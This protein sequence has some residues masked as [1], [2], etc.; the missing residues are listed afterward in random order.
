LGRRLVLSIVLLLAVAAVVVGFVFAGSAGR[1]AA[2][3][4]IAGVDVGGL[5]AK[6]AT[7]KLESRYAAAAATPGA[8]TAGGKTFH[9]PAKELTVH[10]DFSAAVQS[11]LNEGGGSGVVRGF[12]RL[13]LKF[14]PI[15]VDPQVGS[16]DA[17]VKYDM[18]KIAASVDR[19]ERD[20]ELVRHGLHISVSPGQPGLVLDQAAAGRAVVAALASFAR[21]PVALP[22]HRTAPSL[23]VARL[24][25]AQRLA[26]RIVASPVTLRLGATQWRVP[27]W[28]LATLLQ[29][30][31]QLS[32]AGPAADRYFSQLRKRVNEPAKDATW[33]PVA[34][35]KVRLVAAQPGVAL[36]IERS[37]ELLLAAAERT[38]NRLATL[39]T[40]ASTPHR[41]TAQAKAMNIT[42][43]VG[44][45][46]TLYSGVP[47]RLHNVQLVAQ[48][49]DGKLIAPNETFS[50]N[51]ATGERT[52]AKGF[53]V[54]PVIINGEVTTGLGGGVCQVS[55][56]VFNAAFEAGLPIT[57][58]TNHA[59]YISH[60]PLGRDAT[61]DYPDVDLKFVN[62]TGHW[63][64]LRTFV[65][66]DSLSVVLYG[67]PQ[68]RR[69]EATAAPLVV[70]GKLPVKKT[71]DATLKPGEIVVDD[72]G[73]PPQ[74]TSVERKVYAENGTLLSDQTW[75]STYRAE[76]K[77]ERVGRPKKKLP[78]ARP[79]AK[80][81]PASA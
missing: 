67:T 34:G 48:L 71:V 29:L 45:Y 78:K 39:A 54:A 50:F 7:E 40:Q 28:R 43:T 22:V 36:D 20:A 16:Y 62:D 57:S 59:L 80:Q 47:N 33:Q 60:Y 52:A 55:T 4:Q 3:T 76:P 49:I 51:Q 74:K 6:Q 27:R 32:I 64:L 72:P 56:T 1:L 41:S 68:H 42:G 81:A 73:V 19:Q 26:S 66:S 30:G 21:T 69:V 23:T 58:R 35:G 37:A 25:P 70:T 44:S 63:L 14:S 15:S 13:A 8:F 10:V 17:A 24:L 12:R 18:A 5:T 79:A 65:G 77:L 38:Q 53:R 75:Y 11:A 9:I 31:P 46:E 61:V 2:G